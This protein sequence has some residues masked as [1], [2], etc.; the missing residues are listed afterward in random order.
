MAK[1]KLSIEE[2]DNMAVRLWQQGD[3]H[4]ILN[5]CEE[6]ISSEMG[7][8]ELWLKWRSE[9][10]C[11][12][13]EW[14][15]VAAVNK[16]R[17]ALTP[18]LWEAWEL[19][20]LAYTVLKKYKTAAD[21]I[22]IGEQKAQWE[23]IT[24][25]EPNLDEEPAMRAEFYP[26]KID[27]KLLFFRGSGWH[28]YVWYAFYPKLL[29]YAP[30]CAPGWYSL[31]RFYCE[32]LRYFDEAVQAAEKLTALKPKWKPGLALLTQIYSYYAHSE[33]YNKTLYKKY[34]KKAETVYKKLNKD[35]AAARIIE[36][37]KNKDLHVRLEKLKAEKNHRDILALC[38]EALKDKT[39]LDLIIN[40]HWL[41]EQC[42]AYKTL[43]Q[44]KEL[45]AVSK[46]RL[47]NAKKL[48]DLYNR[49]DIG[50]ISEEE[51]A[52]F[53]F[54]DGTES[55]LSNFAWNSAYRRLELEEKDC[56]ENL[57]LAR[58]KLKM[59]VEKMSEKH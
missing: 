21:T 17:T 10:Y 42:E 19:L 39:E 50:E 58:G 41:Y 59:S 56:N 16:E 44:W 57:A 26:Y 8:K 9:A 24:Y 51:E 13:G 31:A 55:E 23:D 3:Y 38:E 18:E 14:K 15:K 2:L 6:M 40:S 52:A 7:P 33:S 48:R 4:G 34:T 45:A 37:K 25:K 20:A 30:E 43:K 53:R 12:L 32:S 11:C 36:T 5:L 47:N 35:K 54:L 27:S 28:K 1:K 29:E 46:K 49:Y 22:R